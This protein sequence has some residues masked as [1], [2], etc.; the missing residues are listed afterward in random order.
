MEGV[1]KHRMVRCEYQFAGCHFKGP[2]LNMPRTTHPRKHYSSPG[3]RLQLSNQPKACLQ[4][5]NSNAAINW[6]TLAAFVVA[7][8]L[9]LSIAMVSLCFIHN[10]LED[11]VKQ[12]IDESDILNDKLANQATEIGQSR[13][14]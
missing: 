8:I 6:F 10:I 7:L 9:I 12:L 13:V 11:S 2:K 3:T 1:C 5:R 4:A 14:S